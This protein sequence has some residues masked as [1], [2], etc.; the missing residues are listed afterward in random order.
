MPADTRRGSDQDVSGTLS[1]LR[2]SVAHG[3]KYF[4]VF[5]V[6]SSTTC[7]SFFAFGMRS[8]IW[9]RNVNDWDGVWIDGRSV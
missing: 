5:F 3:L 9:W 6:Y 4:F 7:L 2:L 1:A 8:Y